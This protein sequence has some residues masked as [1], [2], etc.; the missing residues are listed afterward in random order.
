MIFALF[1]SVAQ[2]YDDT[3]TNT[4]IGKLQRER[5]WNYLEATL[6]NTSINILELSSGTGEDAIWFANKGHTI[7]A[8]DISEQMISI[9][10]KKIK[11]LNLTNNIDAERLDINQIDKLS[12]SNKFDLVF[13]NFGGL[14]CLTED[15]LSLLS[16]KIRNI[17]KPNG[18]FISIVM[19]DFCMIESIYFLFILKFKLIFRRKRMQQVKIND[20]IIDTYYHHPKDFFKFFRNDFTVNNKIGIGLFIPPSYLNNFFKN[21]LNTLNILNKLENIFGN[22][23]FAA[24]LSD[25]YLI[26][27][28]IKQ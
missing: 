13:S 17:L 12:T 9:V 26:D 19:P 4:A 14:N 25:H 16:N 5:V 24:S 6:P 2:E 27:L 18:K 3:F 8:T 22:N 1:D 11:R 21:K 28:N 7:L 20:S 23:D 15:E 10:K